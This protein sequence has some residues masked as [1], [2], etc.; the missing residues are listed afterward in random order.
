MKKII[1]FT[2]DDAHFCNHLLPLA[3]AAKDSGYEVKILTN[4][5]NYKTKIEEHGLGI[6]PLKINRGNINPFV[7]MLLLIRIIRIIR[8]ESPD[9]LH[10]F[11]IKPIFYG[12]I[13]SFFCKIPKIIN[14]FLGMGSVFIGDSLIHKIL[15]ALIS[16]TLSVISKYQNILFIV[17]NS[18]DKKLLE[19][20]GVSGNNPIINQCSVGVDSKD[21]P[22]LPEPKNDKIIFALVARMLV[23]KG[24][25]EFI[26]AA[27]SLRKKGVKAEFW[28]VGSPDEQNPSSIPESILKK[29]NKAGDIK[30][31]GYR[32]DIKN[33]W[34]KAHV[35]VLPSYREGLSRSLLEAGAYGRAVITTDAPG[36]RELIQDQGNGLLVKAK[37][38]KSLSKAMERLVNDKILRQK[39]AA[40][41]RQHIIQ[42]YDTRII[43]K[44]MLKV[45]L[46]KQN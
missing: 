33:I 10:N 8:Q 30:Y 28:L 4:V 32:D 27:K 24:V 1:I 34:E 15:R 23:D 39:L 6:I 22:I 7:E 2:N 41:L 35:A 5:S 20:L 19:E 38:Y 26:K 9:I 36:G 14:N 37:D 17:Q 31:L 3:I 40:S 46:A 12:S 45:Y 43:N 16:Q 11:T 13:A 42:H 25:Y 21:F 29:H 44:N 18:D